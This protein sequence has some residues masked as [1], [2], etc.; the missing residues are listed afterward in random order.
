LPEAAS[1]LDFGPVEI[2]QSKT[3]PFEITNQG[4]APLTLMNNWIAGDSFTVTPQ[5]ARIAPGERVMLSLTYAATSTELEKG[6]LQILSDDPQWPLRQAYLVGNQPGLGVG[7]PLPETTAVL[8]D[9][10][11]WSSSQTE[12]KVLLLAYFATF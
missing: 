7:M 4:T 11:T 1:M 12:G 5:K 9:G 3:L 6:Y 10:S 2:G 8:L